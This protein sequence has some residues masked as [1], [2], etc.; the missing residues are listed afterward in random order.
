MI[1][2]EPNQVCPIKNCEYCDQKN[3]SKYGCMGKNPNRKTVFKCYL[4]ETISNYN[5][6]NN[7]GQIIHG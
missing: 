2:L 5:V 1:K 7:M 4:D 3:A 6:P